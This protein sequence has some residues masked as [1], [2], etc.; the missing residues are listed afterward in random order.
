M[1]LWNFLKGT[2]SCCSKMLAETEVRRYTIAIYDILLLIDSSSYSVRPFVLFLSIGVRIKMFQIYT[3][4]LIL[5]TQIVPKQ[6]KYLN[7]HKTIFERRVW[8]NF[9]YSCVHLNNLRRDDKYCC[10]VRFGHYIGIWFI[11]LPC[12]A[13]VIQEKNRIEEQYLLKVVLFVV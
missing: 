3:L 6:P 8:I 12:N 1:L 10:N 11:R 4:T 2:C 9:F 7:C 13:I 5:P